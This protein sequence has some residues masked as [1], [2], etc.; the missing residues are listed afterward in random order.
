MSV[1]NSIETPETRTQPE[2][3]DVF[4]SYSRRDEDFVRRLAAALEAREKDVWVDWEDIRKT[5]DW[6]GRIQAGIESAK[7]IVAVLSPDFAASD[8]CGEEMEHAVQQNK[9]LVPIVHRDVDRGSFARGAECAELDLLPRVGRLRCVVRRP[10]RGARY[11]PR[12][13]RCSRPPA[14]PRPRMG[15]ERPRPQLPVARQRSRKSRTLAGRTGIAPGDRDSGPGGVR[16]RRTARG[17]APP[18]DDAGRDPPRTRGRSDVGDRRLPPAKHGDRKRGDSALPRVGR[19]VERP[20]GDR[21][22]A[23]RAS[24]HRGGALAGDTGGR[25]RAQDGARP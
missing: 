7:A 25:G 20:A 24:G 19:Q 13:G 14:C 10:R 18:A 21:S 6:R 5:A 12:V 23:E 22:A 4:I 11:G 15:S 17:D 1:T 8:I 3:P 16:R 2:R 9:R